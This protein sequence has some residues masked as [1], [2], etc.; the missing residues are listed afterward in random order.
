MDVVWSWVNSSDPVWRYTHT[1]IEHD[2][3]GEDGEPD[4]DYSVPIVHL[5]NFDE[6]RYSMRSVLKH[7]RP[8]A[9]TFNL[10]A[11]DFAIP[12][13][14]PNAS[15]YPMEYRLG[16]APQWI[17]KERAPLDLMD[18][19]VQL[20]IHH[21]SAYFEPYL[22]TTFSSFGIES[23]LPNLKGMSDIFIYLNDDM[24]LL[25]DL[26]PADFY[27]SAYGFVLRVQ[28]W[29]VV[30]PTRDPRPVRGEWQPLRESNV[31]LSERFGVSARPYL[32]HI[33]KSFSIPVL[34]EMTAIW[35]EAF[36]RTSE[37]QMRDVYRNELGDVH[38]VFLFGHFLVERWRE[39]LLWSWVV[40]RIG[41]D[42]DVFDADGAWNALGGAEEP[43]IMHVPSS[44]R[45]TL[46]LHGVLNTF[47]QAGY[48]YAG[49]THYKFASGDG[50]PYGGFRKGQKDWPTTH[51]ET[52]EMC[53]MRRK[54]CFP[55]AMASASEIFKHV[56]FANPT[57][58]DCIVDSLVR[59]SG[60]L[61][62][63]AFLPPP[64]RTVYPSAI[65]DTA[66]TLPL[67]SEWKDVDFS[68]Y[69]VFAYGRKPFN[70]REWTLRVLDRYRFVLGES[71]SQF[72]FLTSERQAKKA[73]AEVEE[74]KPSLLC[75][76]DDLNSW[77][78]TENVLH[79][80]HDWQEGRFPEPAGWEG[81]HRRSPP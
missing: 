12:E 9:R 78:N 55:P 51:P 67:V 4:F 63:S 65:G 34:R 50:Y 43:D 10:L 18:G 49:D 37:R 80:L 72:Q 19:E 73:V 28:P 13:A 29:I 66:R 14:F 6:L 22:D 25:R 40:G 53:S 32:G 44:E 20:R 62:L 76:N 42:D 57:C 3:S 54:E 52:G 30:P 71:S 58:G 75:M 46:D 7:F 21:H 17:D 59:M 41:T 64:E 69:G 2:L 24:Y 38:T 1:L 26:H 60:K 79:I 68:L 56:A 48:D 8:H 77:A 11:S 23:Q 31:M 81:D 35:P 70:L 5:R 61:G 45:A 16:Q 36:L 15:S 33:A 47:D 74:G 27:T 39:A